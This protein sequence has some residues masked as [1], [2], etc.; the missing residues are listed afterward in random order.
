MS[1]QKT[2][3]IS[4]YVAEVSPTKISARRNKYFD[5]QVAIDESSCRKVRV[6]ET[7]TTTRLL[8]MEKQEAR[9]PVK[10]V[11]I[12]DS[13]NG[14]A[15]F[16]SNMGSKVE[17]VETLPFCFARNEPLNISEIH[18]GVHG[19]NFSVKGKLRWQQEERE[20]FAGGKKVI[21]RVRDGII[22][23]ASGHTLISVWGDLLD[24]ITED[25]AFE[26][27]NVVTQEFHG[28]KLCTTMDTQ[29]K[30]VP[31]DFVV[32]WQEVIEPLEKVCCPTITSVKVSKYCV[33]VNLDCRRKVMPYPGETTVTCH[34]C[35]RKMLLSRC[36]EYACEV[37][38]VDANQ[39]KTI[40]TIFPKVLTEYFGVIDADS[41]E[42]KI[43]TLS[44]TDIE[45]N[46]RNVATKMISHGG[47]EGRMV[48][49]GNADIR[50]D[51][52]N[53]VAK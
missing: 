11:H 25:S 36:N 46:Q 17:A 28:L 48:T 38:F 32:D 10:L 40:V 19:G 5:I 31:D 24:Q 34:G 42:G 39:I 13:E 22:A 44:N 2:S 43:L 30:V 52:R 8:F 50:C 4:G 51:Q 7:P 49:F 41:V 53:V 33:C 26:L 16:N 3:A 15:F 37:S 47:S 23:D 29:F 21:R 9:N 20:V 1:E 12:K 45:Y 18:D 14:I 27:T 6:M 35:R